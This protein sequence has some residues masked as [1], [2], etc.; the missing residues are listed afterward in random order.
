MNSQIW[1]IKYKDLIEKMVT[2]Y[3]GVQLDRD[4]K[5][6]LKLSPEFTL[7]EDINMRQMK[8]DIQICPTKVRWSR[9][10]LKE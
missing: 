5:D 1:K 7:L 4:E 10:G 9:M 6:F 3:G 2:V 8:T